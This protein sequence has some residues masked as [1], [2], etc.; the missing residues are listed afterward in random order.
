[1]NTIL[2]T[3]L[4]AGSLLIGTSAFAG[5]KTISLNVKGMTCVSC[6]HIVKRTL[7]GVEGVKNVDVSFRRKMATIT[8][9]DQVC[10][11][12][13]LAS[14]VTKMGFPSSPVKQEN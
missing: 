12:G 5:E 7:A 14:A 9:D 13:K 1:M 11:P 4:F 3:F 6:P 2:K 8:Y 10:S